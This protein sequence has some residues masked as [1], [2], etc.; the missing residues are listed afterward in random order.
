VTHPD[1]ERYFMTIPE[2]VSLVISAGTFAGGGELYML[3]MGEPI[4]IDNLVKRMIRLRGL[5]PG[6]DIDIQY[7]GL[8][9]GEKL[10]EELI[11]V[12]EE[13]SPTTNPA[14]FALRDERAIGLRELNESVGR[15]AAVARR[16]DSAMVSEMLSN[17]ATSRPADLQQSDAAG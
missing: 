11:F 1:V 13:S 8:R 17:L 2:A 4:R 7:T 5:R 14:V 15:L 3:D 16:G 6:K 10:S 9:P 12:G